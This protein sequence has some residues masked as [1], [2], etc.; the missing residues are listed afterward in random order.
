M[1]AL[2]AH[3]RLLRRVRRMLPAALRPAAVLAPPAGACWDASP[4]AALPLRAG[5]RGMLGLR[6][7]RAAA[8]AIREQGIAWL[9]RAAL[10]QSG[11]VPGW[12]GWRSLPAGG[13]AVFWSTRADAR[14]ALLLDPVCECLWLFWQEPAKEAGPR[15]C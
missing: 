5:G 10:P 11:G 3:V 7:E 8:S 6:L 1:S 12:A 15:C 4:L 9:L 13:H 2:S 14:L